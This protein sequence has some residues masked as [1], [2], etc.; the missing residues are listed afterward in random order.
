MMRDFIFLIGLEHKAGLIACISRFPQRSPEGAQ[1]P[2]HSQPS[3]PPLLPPFLPSRFNQNKGKEQNIGQVS[4]S[5][6]PPCI[7]HVW[8]VAMCPIV[9]QCHERILPLDPPELTHLI[10]EACNLSAS[11][12]GIQHLWNT[13]LLISTV[14]L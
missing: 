7:Q 1:C 14:I 6:S 8:F 4:P 13:I 2:L 5:L 12:L 10:Q 3:L 11:I 9:P